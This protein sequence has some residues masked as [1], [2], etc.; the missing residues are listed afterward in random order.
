[1]NP[2]LIPSGKRTKEYPMKIEKKF[3]KIEDLT[4]CE[5]MFKVNDFKVEIFQVKNKTE[6]E[7][8]RITFDG[9]TFQKYMSVQRVRE[10]LGALH[11]PN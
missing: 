6:Y 3:Q 2:R 10:W 7:L 1:M 11:K 4:I 8:V 9:N 5:N